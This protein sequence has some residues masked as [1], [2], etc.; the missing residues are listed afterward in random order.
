M[1]FAWF[2][3]LGSRQVHQPPPLFW[4]LACCALAGGTLMVAGFAQSSQPPSNTSRP[5]LMPEANRPPDANQ[6]MMMREK[7]QVT[8]NFNAAN[9]ERRKELMEASEM[10]ETM[11]MALKAEMDQSDDLSKNTIHKADTIEKLARIVED[12]MKLS[13]AP[14]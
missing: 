12:K 8:R 10:L 5:L 11:A 6:Q 4:V 14:Q 9:A 3:A 2:R 7:N 13:V 1:P